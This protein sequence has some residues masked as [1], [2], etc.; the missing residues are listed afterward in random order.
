MPEDVLS[1]ACWSELSDDLVQEILRRCALPTLRC[2]SI[3]SKADAVAAETAWHKRADGMGGGWFASLSGGDVGRH[4]ERYP[5]RRA[6]S[7]WPSSSGDNAPQLALR[8]GRIAIAAGSVQA[9]SSSPTS[10]GYSSWAGV[11]L[12]HRGSVQVG[13]PSQ[14]PAVFPY[15]AHLIPETSRAGAVF[16]CNA[17]ALSDTRLAL[18]LLDEDSCVD[19]ATF[20]Y[21]LGA[22]SEPPSAASPEPSVVL[23]FDAV[24]RLAWL[25]DF[26]LRTPQTHPDVAVLVDPD[27]H[28]E[29]STHI[30]MTPG[31]VAVAR[32]RTRVNA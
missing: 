21:D 2:L 9:P 15:P 1:A 4:C 3:V 7:E 13:S 16:T 24:C 28:K 20:V 12:Y 22:L 26:L 30:F 6:R 27:D 19:G 23:P 14:P 10:P 29:R 8:S 17:L 18:S 31:T 11:P 32:A 5:F 25:G